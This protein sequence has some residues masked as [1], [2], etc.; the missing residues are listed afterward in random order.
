MNPNEIN[1]TPFLAGKRK[2]VL[3]V[4][5]VVALVLAV[6]GFMAWSRG[7]GRFAAYDDEQ[8]DKLGLV[9]NQQQ[10]LLFNFKLAGSGEQPFKLASIDQYNGHPDTEV[11]DQPGSYSFSLNEGDI[12]SFTTQFTVPRVMVED[13]SQDRESSRSHGSLAAEEVSFTTPRVGDGAVITIRDPS[14]KVVFTST[15]KDVKVHNNTPEHESL[16]GEDS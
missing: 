2:V 9:A 1:N 4:V 13:F 14:G 12:V 16:A 6:I 7:D 3:I 15:V 8:N 11:T 10:T 5:P